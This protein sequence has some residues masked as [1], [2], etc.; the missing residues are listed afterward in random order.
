M[1]THSKMQE[2][3]THRIAQQFSFADPE[4]LLSLPREVTNDLQSAVSSLRIVDRNG[5]SYRIT[6]EEE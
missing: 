3:I 1:Q 4:G 5:Q 2:Y 6:I